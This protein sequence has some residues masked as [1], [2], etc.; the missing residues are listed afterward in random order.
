M[1]SLKHKNSSPRGKEVTNYLI[2]ICGLTTISYI[3]HNVAHR[4]ICVS[5]VWNV[6]SV[7]KYV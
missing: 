4:Y 1:K 3:W 5:V 6:L 2:M 7:W